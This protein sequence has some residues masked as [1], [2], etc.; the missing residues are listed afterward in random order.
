MLGKIV[1]T[2]NGSKY[3]SDDGIYKEVIAQVDEEI[4]AT[5]IEEY[6]QENPT[7][8]TLVT[9]YEYSENLFDPET[10][11]DWFHTLNTFKKVEVTNNVTTGAN[12]TFMTSTEFLEVEEN[13]EYVIPNTYVGGAYPQFLLFDENKTVVNYNIDG[14]KYGKNVGEDGYLHF[15]VLEGYGVKYFSGNI[16]SYSS[17]CACSPYAYFLRKAEK[18]QY[19][20]T[21]WQ[22]QTDTFAKRPVATKTVDIV[23]FEGQSNMTGLAFSNDFYLNSPVL[24]EGT[25]YEFSFKNYKNGLPF[26]S[27]IKQAQ[28]LFGIGDNYYS[29]DVTEPNK[30]GGVQA[31]LMKKYFEITGVP[32]VGISCSTSGRNIN[33]FIPI[34]DSADEEPCWCNQVVERVKAC[35]EVLT[36][37]GY[38]IKHKYVVWWQGESDGDEFMAKEIY[39]EKIQSIMNMYKENGIEKMFIIRI[40]NC[41]SSTTPRLYDEIQDAQTEIC[42]ENLRERFPNLPWMNMIRES[43]ADPRIIT[44]MRKICA[45]TM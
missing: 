45:N 24:E 5:Q 20:T 23:V 16:A 25:G 28:N 32:M 41:N 13:T 12:W 3:L 1:T 30:L 17:L 36:E 10:D 4:I 14:V 40:G 35:E 34:D 22:K 37:L 42:L 26:S 21:E 8:L 19:Q 38:T 29:N 11:I 39:K 6:M 31:S 27:C 15:T 18:V 2:G 33:N 7:D 9:S 44:H 43:T